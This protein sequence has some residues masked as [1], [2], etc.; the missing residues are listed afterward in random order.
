MTTDTNDKLP[1]PDTDVRAD[2]WGTMSLSQLHRQQDLLLE[3]L[4]RLYALAATGAPTAIGLQKVL[5]LA[6][7]DLTRLI[8]SKSVQPKQKAPDGK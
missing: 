7:S 4:N 2:L 8:E 5:Q 3:R 1:S 6:M